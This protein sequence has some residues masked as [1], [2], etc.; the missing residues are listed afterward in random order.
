MG[1]ANSSLRLPSW[2]A[3][4]SGSSTSMRH[5]RRS[6]V[7]ILVQIIKYFAWYVA[8]MELFLEDVE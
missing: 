6:I 4:H 8:A 1:W 5:F 2:S 3:Q 7:H